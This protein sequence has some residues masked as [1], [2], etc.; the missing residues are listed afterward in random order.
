MDVRIIIPRVPDKRTVYLATKSFVP[1]LVQAGVKIY[2]YT[3][4]FIHAKMVIAD[5][6]RAFIG[7]CNMDYR[8]FYLHY[9]CGALLYNVNTIP[10]MKNDFLA[11]QNESKLVTRE[12]VT[13]GANALK[14]FG[15]AILRLISPMM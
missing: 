15:H 1:V 10:E 4:G 13:G 11:T 8:S 9:E 5:D 7:T 12:E 3:P 2:Y 6:E 14:R